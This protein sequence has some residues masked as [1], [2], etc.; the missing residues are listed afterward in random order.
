MKT[1]QTSLNEK[2]YKQFKKKAA[3]KGISEYALL[4][5]AILKELFNV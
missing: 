3:A 5:S 4:K 1:I 2:E